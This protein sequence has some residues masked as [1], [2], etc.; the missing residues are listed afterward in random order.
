LKHLFSYKDLFES[1]S[2][3]SQD[4]GTADLSPFKFAIN[5]DPR[6]GYTKKDFSMDLIE[7]Y[8]GMSKRERSELMDVVFKSGG[9]FRIS[10]ISELSQETVD[11]I[12][13]NVEALL[14]SKSVYRMQLLPDGYILCYEGLKHKGRLCDVY[15]SPTDEKVKISYTDT[16]PEMEA[17]TI[18]AESFNPSSVNIETDDFLSTKNKCDNFIGTNQIIASKD[19]PDNYSL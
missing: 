8:K 3:G 12:M 4:R 17:V 1:T 2:A 6:L 5:Y 16:Y 7:I 18:S 13:K 9:V 14:D 19:S 11:E 10:E 15:Y